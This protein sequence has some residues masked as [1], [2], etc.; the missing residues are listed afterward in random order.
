[1]IHSFTINRVFDCYHVIKLLGVVSATTP[2]LVVME[3]MLNGDLL[4][5]I[6]RYRRNDSSHNDDDDDELLLGMAAEIADGMAYLGHKHYIHRDLAARNCLVDHNLVVKISAFHSVEEAMPVRWMAPEVLRRPGF[7]VESDVWSFGVVLWEMMSR[8]LRPYM[9][10]SNEKVIPFVGGGGRLVIDSNWPPIAKEIM[11]SCWHERPSQ[12]I[13][14]KEIVENLTNY[15]K[16][17]FLNKSFCY[18][19]YY[20]NSSSSR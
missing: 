5:F 10:L 11:V 17:H 3:M 8:G 19:E 14:F 18:G 9:S 7:N 4:S 1:F 2:C 15:V 16:P 12:R 20:H 6:R 13:S